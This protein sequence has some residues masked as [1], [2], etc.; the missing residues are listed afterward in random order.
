[1]LSSVS[2]AKQPAVRPRGVVS[3]PVPFRLR[4]GAVC[5]FAQRQDEFEHAMAIHRLHVLR[6]NLFRQRPRSIST[7]KKDGSLF[8]ANRSRCRA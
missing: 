6:I 4:C 2:G 7:A 1:M 8:G 5:A 3:P